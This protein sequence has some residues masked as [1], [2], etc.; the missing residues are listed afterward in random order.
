MGTVLKLRSQWWDSQILQVERTWVPVAV[1]L[2]AH[3]NT[4]RGL[5]PGPS[6]KAWHGTVGWEGEAAF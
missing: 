1:S 4:N 5:W 6:V 2:K 3:G